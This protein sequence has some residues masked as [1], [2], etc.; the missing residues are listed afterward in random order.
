MIFVYY[1]MEIRYHTSQEELS[2]ILV[3][4]AENLREALSKDIWTAEG[5][6]TGVYDLEM[7]NLM[8]DQYKHVVSV[9]GDMI[10]G[11]VLCMH[12]SSFSQFEFLRPMQLFFRRLDWGGVKI[13]DLKYV[14]IGQV[15]VR[16][17]YRRQGLSQKMYRLMQEQLRAKWDLAVTLV[18]AENIPS[19][20]AHK[21]F[22]FKEIYQYKEPLGR[23]WVIVA[24]EL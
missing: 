4:Q 5:F 3:L 2:S 23:E 15:C 9:Q 18:D 1:G 7:L 12:P 6:V 16:R 8:C 20:E 14:V 22:G 17:K 21:A 24:F 10:C 19:R 11:Y 13:T